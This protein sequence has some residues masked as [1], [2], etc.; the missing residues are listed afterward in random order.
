MG[1]L[2]LMEMF[3]NNPAFVRW[4]K[5]CM[6]LPLLPCEKITPAWVE[7][8]SEVLPNMDG[9][10]TK[11]KKFHRYVKKF[12]I[13]TKL[14]VLSVFGQPSRT[15]NSSESYNY[16]W[17]ERVAVKHPNFWTFSTHI[18]DSFLDVENDLKRLDA[19]TKISRPKAR[20]N[21][22]NALNLR[23]VCEPYV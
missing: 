22:I 9:F 14:D 13:D 16:K 5:L 4:L 11:Y 6:A 10:I 2:G 17:N 21:V 20:K 1:K 12:G 8:K 23:R 19:G 3:A 15:N 7:L 18:S